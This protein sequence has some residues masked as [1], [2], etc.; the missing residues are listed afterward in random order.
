MGEKSNSSTNIKKVEEY[1]PFPF[2]SEFSLS[3]QWTWM[4]F[5]EKQMFSLPILFFWWLSSLGFDIRVS[6]I[7]LLGLFCIHIIKPY[8][9][10]VFDCS[11]MCIAYTLQFCLDLYYIDRPLS[12]PL[13]NT[14]NTSSNLNLSYISFKLLALE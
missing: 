7:H 10:I 1:N 5:I 14:T 6:L 8:L 2:I 13:P 3:S 11:K 4:A 12:Q 9:S